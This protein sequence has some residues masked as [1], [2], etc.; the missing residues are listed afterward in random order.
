ML[1]EGGVEGVRVAMAISRR[2]ASDSSALGDVMADERSDRSGEEGGSKMEEAKEKKAAAYVARG[3]EAWA[4]KDPEGAVRMYGRALRHRASV[5]P[6]LRRARAYYRL[7]QFQEVEQDCHKA[8]VLERSCPEAMVLLSKA[9]RQ[10]GRIEEAHQVISEAT[11]KHPG[12]SEMKKEYR[13]VKKAIEERDRKEQLMQEAKAGKRAEL[14]EVLEACETMAKIRNS[15]S[16]AKE[17]S[18]I[19]KQCIKKIGESVRDCED[20]QDLLRYLGGIDL[21]TCSLPVDNVAVLQALLQACRRNTASSRVV[22]RDSHLSLIVP[23]V[24]DRRAAV[25]Q[26]V[27][28]I[29]E[30][31][32]PL[33]AFCLER[34]LLNAG[35][36][37]TIVLIGQRAPDILHTSS[38]S[39][40]AEIV[41]LGAA[42]SGDMVPFA[43][44]LIGAAIRGGCSSS[45]SVVK[46]AITILH[47]C[48]D[49][50]HFKTLV[51]AEYSV[52]GLSKRSGLDILLGLVES[53]SE[54]APELEIEIVS[55]GVEVVKR[56]FIEAGVDQIHLL[57][58]AV[59]SV[60]HLLAANPGKVSQLKNI[61]TVAM[62]L[63]LLSHSPS[64]LSSALAHLLV[65]C[66][67]Q[68][69]EF[70]YLI[71]DLGGS[72]AVYTLCIAE[73]SHHSV[74][75]FL[76]L[77]YLALSKNFQEHMKSTKNAES[78]ARLLSVRMKDESTAALADALVKTCRYDAD[79]YHW[80]CCEHDVV[81][82]L[83]QLWYSHA[84]GTKK[85]L[86]ALLSLLL[87]NEAT[88]NTLAEQ[89]EEGQLLRLLHDLRAFS[90]AEQ[91]KATGGASSQVSGM[92]GG[93]RLSQ[94][95]QEV[96]E[97]SR[98][99]NLSKL[100]AYVKTLSSKDQLEDFVLAEYACSTAV[101][102]RSLV[103]WFPDSFT[104]LLMRESALVP[105][106]EQQIFSGQASRV[107]AMEC[108]VEEHGF[109]NVPSCIDVLL[110]IQVWSMLSTFEKEKFFSSIASKLHNDGKVI[111]IEDDINTVG[112]MSEYANTAGFA[113]YA[114]PEI[115][116]EHFTKVFFLP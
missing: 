71:G 104:Y 1:T 114:E 105:K 97:A 60:R 58:L 27:L 23:L 69:V 43:D 62:L 2:V 99:I 52:P 18:Q 81:D 28:K 42:I 82:T 79:F 115:S 94:K 32:A 89:F 37:H 87:E 57:V 107:R 61:G 7:K 11:K 34:T 50:A 55:S 22:V 36:L 116:V 102:G 111:I 86:Q 46:D 16:D 63:P 66:C 88:S 48:S 31:V 53:V 90:I 95:E 24:S 5:K 9:K 4:K 15:G 26:L 73:Y 19:Q 76:L 41:K 64:E 83:V 91:M 68:D 13:M 80:M 72:S 65:T 20:A 108:N 47:F 101:I 103:A 106:V 59:Q 17:D 77:A 85:V 51:S 92:L 21:L 113:E 100:G 25:V 6:L 8:L 56:D 96:D 33:G 35:Q 93:Y 40:L 49:T 44:A 84:G 3:D 12:K 70:A 74:A 45:K 110:C 98:K 10:M 67:K 78:L 14:S 29:L 112:Q 54:E 39:I 109:G 38:L 75:Y 30:E